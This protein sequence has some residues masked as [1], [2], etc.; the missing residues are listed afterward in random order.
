MSELFEGKPTRRAL[1]RTGAAAAALIAAP[2]VL[3][4]QTKEL[5]VGGAAGQEKAREDRVNR[6]FVHV[7]RHNANACP[8][9]T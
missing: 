7:T 8:R 9:A 5:V 2:S 1:L 6:R 3:R 4:A